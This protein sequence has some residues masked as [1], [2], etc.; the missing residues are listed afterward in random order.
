MTTQAGHW[1]RP[2]LC[3]S[4]CGGQHPHPPHRPLSETNSCENMQ[5]QAHSCLFIMERPQQPTGARAAAR[6]GPPGANTV[7]ENTVNTGDPHNPQGRSSAKHWP[8]Y[9]TATTH[10]VHSPLFETLNFQ[11]GVCFRNEHFGRNL[12]RLVTF[13]FFLF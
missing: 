4:K 5:V 2:L 9:L 13:L 6:T 1:H 11:P 7:S 12:R 10:S 8:L 3:N